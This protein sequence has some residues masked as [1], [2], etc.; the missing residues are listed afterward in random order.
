M[1]R[2]TAAVRA[3]YEAYPYPPGNRPDCD[4][5]HGR[6]LLSYIERCAG[7]PRQ[8]Q[9]L[10]AG[11]G[12]GI[13]L[14]EVAALQP[15][16][17]FTGIDINRVAIDEASA[18][19]RNKA[20][21]NLS[22]HLADLLDPASLP[23]VSRGYDVILSYGVIHHLSDPLKGLQQLTQQLAPH[24]VLSLM[25][26]GRYG[27]QPLDRFLQALQMVSP[28]VDQDGQRAATARA[29][30]RIADRGVFHGNCW[31]GTSSVDEV[32]FA[33]RCLHVHEQSY[34]IEALLQLLD[35]AG[36][37]FIRWHEPDDWS[38]KTI[39]DDEELIEQLQSV[40]PSIT[41]QLIE[42]L[43]YRP[44][45]TLVAARKEDQ[46]RH[47]PTRQ[48]FLSKRFYLSPQLKRVTDGAGE[49]GWL[50]RG[51]KLSIDAQGLPHRLLTAASQSDSG[52]SASQL[53]QQLPGESID[54]QQALNLFMHL[55]DLECLYAPH[56]TDRS[57]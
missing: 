14:T 24:G 51:R 44:K 22:F 32:E 17:Q 38:L 54:Q 1:D 11:C 25:V 49:T 52:F 20:L 18:N 46:P 31:Q 28:S 3:F 10:E 43:T 8:L 33:D 23:G 53:S 4:A 13:N 57:A 50:L 41:Y 40:D 16:D 26:D 35:K 39:C 37:K 42:R 30:A 7:L 47:R 29:L 2:V 48:E 34:D 55:Y 5:Y 56:E 19:I 36:L 27:R 15:D 9:L 12:R 45:L 21:A 6:L